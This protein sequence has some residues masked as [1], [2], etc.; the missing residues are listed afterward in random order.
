VRSFSS[1]LSPLVRIWRALSAIAHCS[2]LRLLILLSQT[3]RRSGWRRD[4]AKRSNQVQGSFR[5]RV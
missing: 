4:Q 1:A 5:S 3:R 2:L